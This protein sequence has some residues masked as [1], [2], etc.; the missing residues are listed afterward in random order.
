MPAEHLRALIVE[1]RPGVS[2]RQLEALAG[3]AEGAISFYLR[4]T[5]IIDS[6]PKTA[7]CKEIETALG[8]GLD[9]VVEAF[10]AD[11][12]LPWGP[13]LDDPEERQLMHNYRRLPIEHRHAL[14][15]M[16]QSLAGGPRP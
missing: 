13:S 6:I 7:R 11:A 5:T 12:G 15:L 1:C 2:I 16:A 10:A 4:K 8:C 3:L 9:R 14:G